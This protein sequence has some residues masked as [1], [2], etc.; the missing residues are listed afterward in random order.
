MVALANP[1]QTNQKN[2]DKAASPGADREWES[3]RLAATSRRR[4]KWAL[5]AAAL[6]VGG[7]AA[8]AWAG[9]AGEETGAV[10]VLADDLPAGHVITAGD[11][12][13]VEVA[14]ADGLRLMAP[15][16]VEGMALTLPVPGG[17]PLTAGAVSD[18]ALWPEEGSAVVTVPVTALPHGLE[19]GTTV[20][21]IPAEGGAEAAAESGEGQP[22]EAPGAVT[23]LVHRVVA[24]A[25][26]GFGTGAQAVEVVV[27]RADAGQVARAVAGGDIQVAVVNPHEQAQSEDEEAG[28]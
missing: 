7:G 5:L 27:S 26:D 22:D 25:D 2:K 4:W 3:V 9:Y 24:E 16:A 19:A 20:E 8:G 10:A 17:S 23:A 28:E 11:V 14:E 13:T 18:T 15:E 12:T 1:Q 21:L 6:I